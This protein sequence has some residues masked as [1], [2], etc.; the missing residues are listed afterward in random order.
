MQG[1]GVG[2]AVVD[3]SQFAAQ[4]R[5]VDGPGRAALGPGG[6]VRGAGVVEGF[7]P[8]QAASPLQAGAL[9]QGG[10][11]FEAVGDAV[12]G[13]ARSVENSG[14]RST[15]IPHINCLLAI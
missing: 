3:R 4:A 13:L 9:A 11:E 8:F 5:D 14:A 7:D 10:I 12:L 2:G 1:R 6:G 15:L